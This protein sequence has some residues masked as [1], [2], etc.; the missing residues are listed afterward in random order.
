MGFEPQ[1]LNKRKSKTPAAKPW[2]RTKKVNFGDF[3][4]QDIQKE[5]D[6]EEY[7]WKRIDS[8]VSCPASMG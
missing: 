7:V 3:K 5:L 1:F 4:I 2:Q 6:C 8:D